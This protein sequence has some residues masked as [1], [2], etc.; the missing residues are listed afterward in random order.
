VRLLR[1]PFTLFARA[2]RR[3]PRLR[4]LLVRLVIICVVAVGIA[5]SVG[6]ILLNNVVIHRTAE[7]GKLD[8]ERRELRRDNA[9]LDA[10]AAVKSSQTVISRRAER[11]LGM[12]RSGAASTYTYLDPHSSDLVAKQKAT[13]AARAR[14]R[15]RQQAAAQQQSARAHQ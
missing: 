7:L 5:G 11:E 3:S 9:V 1:L 15:A 10:Q 14:A 12:R 2:V 8:Q 13:L 4:K 6:V